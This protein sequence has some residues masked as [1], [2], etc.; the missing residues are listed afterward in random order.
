V[1]KTTSRKFVILPVPWLSGYF[2]G[3]IPRSNGIKSNAELKK[4]LAFNAQDFLDS[5]GVA[6]KVTEFKKKEAIFS[7]GDPAKDVFYI[8][9]GNESGKEAVVAVLEAG[10]HSTD[11]L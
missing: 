8:Q 11:L 7:Q 3:T 2:V 1:S 9:K 4:K 5:T 10:T 6:R